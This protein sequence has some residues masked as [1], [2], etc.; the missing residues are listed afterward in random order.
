MATIC[1]KC[2]EKHEEGKLCICEITEKKELL[3]NRKKTF[4]LKKNT[5]GDLLNHLLKSRNISKTYEEFIAINFQ[6]L[7]N[8]GFLNQKAG[9]N[10][11]IQALEAG[12]K[13]AIYGDYDADGIT[14]TV[15]GYTGVRGLGGK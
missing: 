9:V 8:E 6:E 13:I 12:E 10:R 15:L 11:I 7:Y 3:K 5:T 2:G 14:G 4:Y 1:T